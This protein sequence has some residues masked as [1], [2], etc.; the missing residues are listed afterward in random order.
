M[1][2][3]CH[4]LNKQ[5]PKPILHNL[6]CGKVRSSSA[7]RACRPAT[8]SC[9]CTG[10]TANRWCSGPRWPWTGCLRRP[11]QTALSAGQTRCLQGM[12][13]PLALPALSA[14]QC[15]PLHLHINPSAGLVIQRASAAQGW[16]APGPVCF[17][18]KFSSAN[19]APAP[20]TAPQSALPVVHPWSLGPQQA[21][22]WPLTRTVD[23]LAAGAV[24]GCEVTALQS[25]EQT[26]HV[27]KRASADC[28]SKRC[29]AQTAKIY[30]AHEVGDDAVERRALEVQGLAHAAH[31]LL[32]CMIICMIM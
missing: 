23:G 18:W 26:R 1:P 32:A 3:Y 11:Q 7:P 6:F 31:A 15:D 9:W 4:G 25:G 22:V 20:P 12:R 10:R 27:K 2:L 14:A 5:V 19:L 29:E 21:P 30:L 16:G 17:S 8:P 24:A 13:R 28:D